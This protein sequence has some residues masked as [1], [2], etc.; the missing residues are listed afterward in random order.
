MNKGGMMG[1]KGKTVLNKASLREMAEELTTFFDELQPPE[2]D[3]ETTPVERALLSTL[4]DIATH[5][6]KELKSRKTLTEDQWRA[7]CNQAIATVCARG[8][9]E[10][11]KGVSESDVR[12]LVT[13]E[14]MMIPFET[15][16]KA[17]L[18]R[19]SHEREPG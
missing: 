12:E 8:Q 7:M 16:A 3:T 10:G 14:R 2:G 5:V 1:T 6:G 17:Q 18:L 19:P 9:A 15:S 11:N 4:R 13:A